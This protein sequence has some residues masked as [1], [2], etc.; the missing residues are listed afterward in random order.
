MIIPPLG[1]QVRL[2]NGSIMTYVRAEGM[3]AILRDKDGKEY[4]KLFKEITIINKNGN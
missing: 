2:P 4:A 1:A 3:Y